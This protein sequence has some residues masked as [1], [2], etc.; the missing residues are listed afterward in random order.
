MCPTPIEAAAAP[1]PPQMIRF[2]G[3]AERLRALLSRAT[4]TRGTGTNEVFRHMMVLAAGSGAAKAVGALT[5]PIVTRLYSPE[6][7]GLFTLFLSITATLTPLMSLRYS[8][9]LPLPRRDGT[10][11]SLLV[12]CAGILILMS[13][14]MT[15]VFTLF[16]EKI[17][18]LF[19]I[20]QLAPMGPW[21]VAA[22]SAA[23]LYEILTNWGVRKR[24]FKMLAKAEVSQSVLAGG[25]KIGFSYLALQQIG[26]IVAHVLSQLTVC[27][28]IV[29]AVWKETSKLLLRTNVKKIWFM[30]TFYSDFPKF[31]LASQLLLIV[32]VQAPIFFIGASFGPATAGQ[33]GLALVAL[34]VPLTLLG[35]TTGQA[36]YSEIARIGIKEP[37]KILDITTGVIK[38]L[39]V[40]GLAPTV[41]LM[42]G[43]TYLFPIFFGKQWHAAGVFCAILSIYL[44]AQFVA[45]PLGHVLSVFKKQYLFL[46]INIVRVLLILAIF[47]FSNRMELTANTTIAIYSVALS[48]HYL[49]TS[50]AI[51]SIIKREVDKKNLLY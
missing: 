42:F 10:A 4:E 7:F 17:F 51:L 26:L 22:L 9:A 37:A 34:A 45:S 32:A 27:I 33:L 21:I 3:V 14:S 39:F 2:S 46:R 31:R 38:R 1:P 30:L 50:Y 6:Q 8:A 49:V 20:Q 29:C 19:S 24:S 16:S 28:I 47:Y 44:L 40:M 43:S 18:S 5:I 48:V 36:Y 23:G 13:I 11:V 15:I 25:M 12:A 35:Q 41:I